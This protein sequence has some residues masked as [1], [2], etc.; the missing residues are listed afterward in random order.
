[1]ARTKHLGAVCAP[2]EL[3]KRRANS[4]KT[5]VS[6]ARGLEKKSDLVNSTVGEFN[7]ST[8]VGTRRVVELEEMR[9]VCR[10]KR[11]RSIR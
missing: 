1:M 10:S 6:L 7:G 9:S 11:A 4:F 5:S 8:W 3:G 2:I